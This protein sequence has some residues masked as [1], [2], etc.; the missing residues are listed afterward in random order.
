MQNAAGVPHERLQLDATAD[1][2]GDR[3]RSLLAVCAV[4]VSERLT[5]PDAAAPFDPTTLPAPWLAGGS[6]APADDGSR[7]E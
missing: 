3:E 7:P 4:A 5:K 2:P 1:G 6:A